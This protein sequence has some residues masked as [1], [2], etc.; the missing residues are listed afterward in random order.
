MQPFELRE[1]ALSQASDAKRSECLRFPV[2]GRPVHQGVPVDDWN[3]G[4]PQNTVANLAT[5]RTERTVVRPNPG[6]RECLEPGVVEISQAPTARKTVLERGPDA[7]GLEN[8]WRDELCQTGVSAAVAIVR[9]HLFGMVVYRRPGRQVE[10]DL[11]LI[12]VLI[13]KPAGFERI[14]VSCR[15]GTD[16]LSVWRAANRFQGMNLKKAGALVDREPCHPIKFVHVVEREGENE[17]EGDAGT[18]RAH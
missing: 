9:K 17:T 12:P 18:V 5:Q 11:Y 16:S 2:H 7:I 6:R 1:R 14:L 15:S 10:L 13:P 3:R 4:L 8:Q